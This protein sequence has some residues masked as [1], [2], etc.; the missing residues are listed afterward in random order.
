M[1]ANKFRALMGKVESGDYETGNVDASQLDRDPKQDSDYQS[2]DTGMQMEQYATAQ[3][4]QNSSGPFKNPNS[5]VPDFI[6][7]AMAES[8]GNA[9]VSGVLYKNINKSKMPDFIKQAMLDKPIDPHNPNTNLYNESAPP[10]PPQ[11]PAHSKQRF[12]EQRSTQQFAGLTES[13]I[14]E[15]VQ[16][17][18]INFFANQF[19]T[20]LSES[21][22]RQVLDNLVDRGILKKKKK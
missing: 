3:P 20:K 11:Q 2:Q 18:M 6:K 22:E 12:N 10:T 21:V 15:I 1:D 14:R 4:Q 17:E 9:N 8:A 13:Q 19:K 16:D 7:Q 5:K